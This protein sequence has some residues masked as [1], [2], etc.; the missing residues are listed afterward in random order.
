[1]PSNREWTIRAKE[2]RE[3]YGC[4]SSLS[5]P[6]AFGKLMAD[7]HEFYGKLVKQIKK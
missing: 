6:E 1:M 4:E 5:G 3:G 7:D 2:E